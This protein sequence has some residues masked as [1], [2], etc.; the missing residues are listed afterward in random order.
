MVNG[1]TVSQYTDAVSYLL[2]PIGADLLPL[3]I[4]ASLSLS[5]FTSATSPSAA[6]PHIKS[7]Q[8]GII[9]FASR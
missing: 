9:R 5:S 6:Q 7:K 2:F 8:L 1:L 4:T 3:H